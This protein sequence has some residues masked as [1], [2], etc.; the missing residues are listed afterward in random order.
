MNE[1]SG[2][3]AIR[4][5]DYVIIP[6]DDM[7][8]MRAFYTDVMQLEVHDEGPDW[9][10]LQVGAL[11]IGLRPRGRGYDGPQGPT[12][13]AAVQL[14]FRVPPA[15]VDAAYETL[16]E[17]AVSVIEA[18]T[19]QDQD[20]GHRTLY[21]A[22]PENNIIEIYADIHPRDAGSGHSPIHDR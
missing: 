20:W 12:K 5:L 14:S 9:I 22:D 21:F 15:D 16:Q 4:S 17:R 7:A 2:F 19:S 18:P 1:N 13:S 10:G 3:G 6:C 11:F 8:V